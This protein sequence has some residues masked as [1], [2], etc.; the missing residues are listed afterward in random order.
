M[1]PTTRGVV[2]FVTA[3]VLFALAWQTRIGWFYVVDAAIGGIL[4]VNAL[5]P[6]LNLR[7]LSARRWVA[8]YSGGAD[9]ARD[10]FEGDTIELGIEV[11]S[12]FILPK[13]FLVL[14][15]ECPL[16]DPEEA[17]T[18]FLIDALGARGRAQVTYAVE[19]YQRG[20]YS[21]GPLRLQSTAPFGLFRS[22]RTLSAPL[23][24]TV[25]P[26]SAPLGGLPHGGFLQGQLLESGPPRPS[27]E[28]R[29]S[30]EYQPGDQSRA[31]HWRNSARRGHLMVKEFDQV[32]EGEV[33]VAFNPS[34]KAGEGRES[35]LEYGVRV[36]ASVAHQ[37]VREGRPFRLW[38]SARGGTFPT[39]HATLEYLAR[40][41]PP[42][43]KDAAEPAIDALLRAPQGTGTSVAILS[44]ADD[45][46]LQT[47]R[48]SGGVY[49][50]R[51]TVVVLE[52][53][54]PAAEDAS[55]V[56]QLVDL[57]LAVIRCRPGALREAMALIGRRPS[58]QGV[59][60]R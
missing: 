40:V 43:E 49:G 9:T 39:W 21:F 22:R 6:W 16:A 53:F 36:A 35:A 38:T 33:R 4:L 11:S 24:V 54:D 31:I 46:A 26:E 50:R 29:G 58:R 57:G 19:P 32:P 42:G 1:V 20:V 45:K 5:I 47:I 12:R 56:D 34:L 25:Y 13:L 30:R 2:T 48:R 7:G 37:A 44:A 55:A 41:E 14:E 23:E 10:I 17:D 27:G 8:R 51:L 18:D 60:W 28:V 52:G 3:V 59:A 15:E